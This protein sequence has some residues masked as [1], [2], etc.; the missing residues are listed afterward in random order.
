MTKTKSATKSATVVSD[1]VADLKRGIYAMIGAGV[2]DDLIMEITGVPRT[3]LTSMKGAYN[4]GKSPVT[5]TRH[6][7][8]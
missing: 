5:V 6:D 2:P 3:N 1:P 8:A 7:V 4:S